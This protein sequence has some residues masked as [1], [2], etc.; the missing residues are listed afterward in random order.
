MSNNI[1]FICTDCENEISCCVCDRVIYANM[2]GA[3]LGYVLRD[4]GLFN[5]KDTYIDYLFQKPQSCIKLTF[6][7]TDRFMS[8]DRK[9]QLDL[10]QYKSKYH[11]RLFNNLLKCYDCNDNKKY[12]YQILLTDDE[13]EVIKKILPKYKTM[14]NYVDK[15]F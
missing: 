6:P 5:I 3:S 7:T 2:T 11:F 4:L 8:L 13:C 14:K 12:V 15:D 9:T 1:E 10:Y